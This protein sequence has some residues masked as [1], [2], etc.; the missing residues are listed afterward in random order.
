MHILSMA[1][2][3]LISSTPAATTVPN[4]FEKRH[5]GQQDLRALLSCKR[6]LLVNFTETGFFGALGKWLDAKNYFQRVSTYDTLSSQV[7]AS[8]HL[9]SSMP[10]F[11]FLHLEPNP[12]AALS[13][14]NFAK[15]FCRNAKIV[16][17]YPGSK[18]DF[19]ML[20]KN[21]HGF[22]VYDCL[23]PDNGYARLRGM[24]KRLCA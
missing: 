24:L 4:G 15:S 22:A 19:G 12:Q 18:D 1:Q 6:A 20:F 7:D 14:A 5:M 10:D 21:P 3:T 23:S 8:E 9:Q 2:K 13:F 16:L 11:V 17:F